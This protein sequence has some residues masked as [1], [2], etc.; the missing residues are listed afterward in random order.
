MEVAIRG[1][2]ISQVA[3]TD[4]KAQK[5]LQR[6]A[7]VALLGRKYKLGGIH[8]NRVHIDRNKPSYGVWGASTTL[9]PPEKRAGEKIGSVWSI[10]G[11]LVVDGNGTRQTATELTAWLVIMWGSWRGVT[12]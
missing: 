9:L 8:A 2:K 5:N 1:A 6:I 10:R 4:K 3:E 7:D 11:G 12:Y